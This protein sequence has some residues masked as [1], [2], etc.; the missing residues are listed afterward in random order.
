MSKIIS[1]LLSGLSGLEIGR[2]SWNQFGINAKNVDIPNREEW[3]SRSKSIGHEPVKVDIEADASNIPVESNSQDFVFS[4]HMFEHHQN[5]IAVMCEWW[6]VIGI[7]GLMVA[8]IPKHDSHPDDVGKPITPL[9][10]IIDRC[11]N[12]EKYNMDCSIF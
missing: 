9:S 11:L 5:P 7:G 1:Q 8:I 10:E 2:S 12:H 3:I 4:S 6:R